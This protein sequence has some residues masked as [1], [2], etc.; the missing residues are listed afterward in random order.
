MLGS[1]EQRTVVPRLEDRLSRYF[2]GG[3]DVQVIPRRDKGAVH[4]RVGNSAER[5][6]HEWGD[7]VQQVVILLLPIVEHEN[8]ALMYFLE[9]PEVYLHAGWQRMLAKA[10]IEAPNSH[11]LVLASTHSTYFLD[12]CEMLGGSSFCQ[13][14]VDGEIDLAVP[15]GGVDSIVSIRCSRSADLDIIRELGVLPS[16]VLLANCSVW[17]EGITDRLYFSKLF[18]LLV[19]SDSEFSQNGRLIE[20]INFA[21]V[22]YGGAA[23]THL[24]EADDDEKMNLSKLCGRAILIVDADS[25]RKGSRGQV[26]S[27]VFGDRY[28][29][30]EVEELECL[31]PPDVIRR[32]VRRYE[33]DDVPFRAFTHEEYQSVKLGGFI[34]SIWPAG[35]SSRR[36]KRTI[37]ADGIGGAYGTKTGTVKSKLE[38]WRHAISELDELEA[39]GSVAIEFGRRVLR[40]IRDISIC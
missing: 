23:V 15:E 1:R 12:V 13:L 40:R 24:G 31:L 11:L 29:P 33:G 30:L 27:A 36:L 4:F 20:G 5:A 6:I 32:V 35:T 37:D 22:E 9:E 18:R 2:F 16:A 26:L 34:D 8:R 7:A 38:F 28:F 10:I 14:R 39:F 19:E 21:F 3:A 25:H 17:V